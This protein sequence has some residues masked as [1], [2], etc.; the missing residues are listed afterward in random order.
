MAEVAFGL[1]ISAAEHSIVR[2][3][4]CSYVAARGDGHDA[5]AP[6]YH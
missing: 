4:T 6:D 3:C 1:Q 2:M 5:A